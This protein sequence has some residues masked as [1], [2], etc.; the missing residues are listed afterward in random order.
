M[1]EKLLVQNVIDKYFND[2]PDSF[3][4]HH[5]D[6]YNKFFDHDIK[7]VFKEN[8][9]IQIMKEKN[10]ETDD[11]NFKCKLF[12]GGK[13][14]D[15]LY[16]GKPII[17]DDDKSQF[18][19]PNIARLRN[20]TY[21]ITVHY[22]VDVEIII[23][24]KQQTSDNEKENLQ[25][26]KNI[27]L[28]KIFLGRFPIMLRSNQCVLKNLTKSVR[29][30]LGECRNDYGGYFIIDGKEK[31][32]VSQEKFA[33]NMLYIKDKVNEIYSHS[34]DIRSVSEDSSKP[35]RTLQ[36]RMVSPTSTLSNNNIVVNIPNVRK[37]VPL[38]ILMRAL[39]IE[40][41]KS[42]IETCLL[43]LEKNKSYMELLIPSI[44]DANKMFNQNVALK[45]IASLTKGKTIPHA[46]E[47]LTNYLLPHVGEMNF[48]DKAYFIGYMVKELLRVYK[49]EIKPTDR[50]NFKYKRVELPGNLIYDL[51]NEY[52]KIQ[53]KKIFQ[54][55]DKEFHYKQ[56]IYTKDFASLIELNYKEFFAE[57]FVEDGF[58]KAF[59]GN[60]GAT[61]H[62]K[63]MGLIQDLNRL[64]Y[65][66]AISHLRK[67]NLDI[68]ASAKIVGPRLLHSTQWGIIDPIDTPD[69]GN[70]GLHKHLA[71][72]ANITSGCSS[73]PMIKW[74]RKHIKYTLLTENSPSD[75]SNMCKI[76]V[77]GNW[78][79]VLNNPSESLKKIKQYRRSALI[80]IFTSVNWDLTENVINIYTDSGR[81]CRPIFYND[82]NK[83]SYN[84]DFI[85][86]KIKKNDFSWEELVT[87]F[88]KKNKSFNYKDLCAYMKIS[89][90]YNTNNL[91]E[92]EET[93]AVI[94]Y[95]DTAE[96]ET[97]LISFNPDDMEKKYFTHLEIHPSLLLGVM[98]NQVVFP[99]NN[100]L[101]RDLFACGQMR[102]AVSLY[103]SNFQTRIDTMGVVLNNG[104][105]PLVK[106]RILKH[107]NNEEHPY[108]ENVI[109]AIMCYGGYNVEDSILFNEASVKRGLFRTTYFNMYEDREDSS[110]VGNSEVNS[111]F[112][113]IENTNVTRLKPGY[114]Y[115][116]LD[117]NGLIKENT[118]LDDKK[119]MIGKTTSNINDP[120]TF[121]DA[122]VFSKKGQL[123]YVD[124]VFVS[125]GSEGFRT[126]K[127]RVRHERIPNIG[128]KFCSRC[129]Q[130]GTI[131]LVIPEEDMPFTEDGIRPDIIINPHAFPSRMTIGQLVETQMGKACLIAG[132][133]GDCT[134]FM[135]EG[136]KHEIFGKV[137]SD[138][139]Y[140]SNGCQILY[141]GE[142]G[143]Q[144]QADIY[145]GPS[146]YMRLKH[147]VKD[148]INYRSKGPRQALTRQTVQ[149]RANDGGLRIGEMERD[150][151]IA[152]GATKFLQESMLVRGDEYFVAICNQTGMITIYNESRNLFMSPYVDGPIKFAE[153]IDETS[154]GNIENI[155]RYGRSFSIVR[156]PYTFKLLIQELQT[157]NVQLRIITD[158][159]IDSLSSMISSNNI[160]NLL[161]DEANPLT[162][163]KETRDKLNKNKKSNMYS[164]EDNIKLDNIEDDLE[165][166]KD[167]N[168]INISQPNTNI[169]INTNQ[170]SPAYAPASPTYAPGSPTYAPASPT[171]APGSP[172][173]T[174]ASPI[175]APG[176]P[177]YAPGSPTYAL[178]SPT[179]APGS[180]TYAPGS[181]TY[182]P[183]SPVNAI[184]QQELSN[185]PNEKMLNE[186]MIKN[187]DNIVSVETAPV[188]T[189]PAEVITIE[190]PATD[191]TSLETSSIKQPITSE[192]DLNLLTNIDKKNDEEENEDNIKKI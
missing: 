155:S 82:N 138:S 55:I 90:L 19:Y 179:Y 34:A 130:K 14:G 192:N 128:D 190:T 61:A 158:K 25:E 177:T 27:T 139:G 52:Y 172:A 17:Y 116:D 39:G 101:P 134:A 86:E 183:G 45:Y 159:N 169:S 152:H 92:L 141:N 53:H 15:K 95:L 109:T 161:G 137:L 74:L 189:A 166:I 104:Q 33:D 78:I 59:K 26:V 73:Y 88:A 32:I 6:S 180:P 77:N 165:E 129:G 16:Y 1:N 8:N 36:V 100:Q 127:V 173:Y 98:G 164:Q 21:A 80:P 51:F 69:G 83:A 35:I 170:A 29:F 31:C 38:F 46:L 149:G 151:I 103:H 7:R 57:R 63:K 84:K 50:D 23:A 65:N 3:V 97:T 126:A 85:I 163:V 9:P 188:E 44:H 118:L 160:I 60:W 5:L 185:N 186:V 184:S 102:Q 93:K 30:E 71:I 132:G 12:L 62:T 49:K 107:I 157:M 154:V 18:M 64:S 108:G 72:T 89:D 121:T 146:Y 22:D 81:L 58:K 37:P 20:M 47:I 11:F 168:E 147:M 191:E 75:I 54:K 56:G 171:Y 67:I 24:N 110:T 28:D 162:I 4:K 42:I 182:A 187:P 119:V 136:P 117:D 122:S 41:D 123:G 94:E 48:K 133:F 79:G 76:F 99:E 153:T 113:N 125:E 70:V 112:A 135:N 175:Y 174:P 144:I 111:F 91:N 181:P 120:D 124:K 105:I 40:S 10:I 176:S 142:S 143:E 43:D 106:S 131:G 2:N 114:D 145:V 115:S 87:G 140:N 96:T 150:G 13:N 68:D 156:I 167:D 66:S 178:G 148:K